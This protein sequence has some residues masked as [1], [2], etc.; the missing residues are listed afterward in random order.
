MKLQRIYPINDFEVALG[1][2]QGLSKRPS[3]ST[4]SALSQMEALVMKL[5]G[6]GLKEDLS[7]VVVSPT[8]EGVWEEVR[9]RA[10]DWKDFTTAVSSGPHPQQREQKDSKI[11]SNSPLFLKTAMKW[12]PLSE[13]AVNR[14]L[15]EGEMLYFHLTGSLPEAGNSIFEDPVAKWKAQFQFRISHHLIQEAVDQLDNIPEACK[16]EGLLKV[17]RKHPGEQ[18]E[19]FTHPVEILSILLEEDCTSYGQYVL[20]EKLIEQGLWLKTE[21][22][23]FEQWIQF[24]A[25]TGLLL[26]TTCPHKSN[27]K[28]PI[29]SKSPIFRYQ[30]NP[31]A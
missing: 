17:F 18:E 22:S 7:G 15:Y 30:T 4:R 31:A 24:L 6:K 10:Q 9:I 20:E 23:S 26:E 3:S 1:K 13:D 19:C 21:W 29:L 25:R 27:H 5:C 28:N 2:C 16:S 12:I 14:I 8:G 11:L